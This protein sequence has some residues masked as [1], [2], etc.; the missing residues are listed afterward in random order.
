MLHGAI[1]SFLGNFTVPAEGRRAEVPEMGERRGRNSIALQRPE[2]YLKF[3][4]L[5]TVIDGVD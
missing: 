5:S 4:G 1:R 3:I 2:E